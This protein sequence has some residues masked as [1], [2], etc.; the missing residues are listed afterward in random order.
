MI[1]RLIGKIALWIWLF[2]TVI[3]GL[4]LIHRLRNP[5]WKSISDTDFINYAKFSFLLLAVYIVTKL[6]IKVKKE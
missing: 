3:V 6:I 4:F 5:G 1:I 2:L